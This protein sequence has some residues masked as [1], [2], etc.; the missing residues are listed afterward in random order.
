MVR[1]HIHHE[2]ATT[3]EYIKILANPDLPIHQDLATA[4]HPRLKS[5]KP[6]WIQAVTLI[7]EE[8][9][10]LFTVQVVNLSPED[11]WSQARTRHGTLSC[12]KSV[13]S[14]EMCETDASDRG[15]GAV[16]SQVVEGEE[17]HREGES[18]HQVG[19]PHSPL[20]FVGTS[21]HPL[22]GPHPLQWLHRMKDVNAQITRWYLALQPFNFEVVHRLGAQMAVTEVLS[23]KGVERAV[24]KVLLA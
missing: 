14:S 9:K 3:R 8:K 19:S 22:F 12:V 11:I 5:R 18:G 16:L 7:A 6:F 24:W 23:R 1:I 2:S 4:L 20:L 15:L 17:H 10:L 21:I 13:K